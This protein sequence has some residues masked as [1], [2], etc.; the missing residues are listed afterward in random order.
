MVHPPSLPPWCAGIPEDPGMIPQALSDVFAYIEEV[1]CARQYMHVH[2][3]V[4]VM[5]AA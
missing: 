5:S 4:G 1:G 2:L 3:Y